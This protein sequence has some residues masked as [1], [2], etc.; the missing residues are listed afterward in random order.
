MAGDLEASI[1]IRVLDGFT[2]PL[3]ALGTSLEMTEE[4]AKKLSKAFNMSADLNQSAEAMGRF[5]NML[6]SPM[7]SAVDEFRGFE[8]EMSKVSALSGEIGTEGFAK[9]REQAL[10]L[11]AATAYSSEEAAQAM[12]QYAQAGRTVNEILEVTPL[13]LAAAKANGT[14]L[15]ETAAII[16][17]TMSGMGISTKETAR[18]V[19]VLTAGAAASDM[20]LQDMGQALAYVGPVARQAGMSLE[21]TAAFMGKMKDS[22]L[23]ASSVG[24]GLRA[25]LSRLL[26]PSKEATKAFGKLGIGS[27]QLAEVQKLVASGK[28]DEALRR[29]GAAADKL[30][31]EQRLKL[32]SQIFGIEASTAANVAISASMDVSDKG[33]RALEQNLLKSTGTTLRLAGVMEDNLDGSIEKASGAISGLSTKIGE[34]LKPTVEHGAKEVEKLANKTLAWINQHPDATRATLEFTATIAGLALVMKAGLVAASAYVSANAMLVKSYTALTGSLIGRLGLVAA[35]GAAGY[36]IGTWANDTFKL[37]DKISSALGHEGPATGKK[38]LDKKGDQVYA[39]GTVMSSTGRV[40]KLGK[41]P[42]LAPKAVR[43]ARAAG[44]SSLEEINTHIEQA[45]AWKKADARA[46]K[47]RAWRAFDPETPE[48]APKNKPG[49]WATPQPAEPAVKEQTVLLMR[50]TKDQTAEL[51]SAL[52][53]QTKTSEQIMEQLRKNSRNRAAAGAGIGGEGAF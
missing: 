11:G 41:N 37:A 42:K 2:A 39:D 35:A 32:L 10:E 44:A 19:D 36:A 17:H 24:T 51:V 4:K 3:R 14:G 5:A 1:V 27:K 21:L 28:A 30:P 46:G 16:G 22:G 49:P 9:M 18:A 47:P 26:D 38:G 48:A 40:L 20:T 33:L 50:A 31:N 53:D 7:K 52:R 34:V 25:V 29:I 43:D 8:K 45:D 13:T 6:I 15:A 12:A 23:E